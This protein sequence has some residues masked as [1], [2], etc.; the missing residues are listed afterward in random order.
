MVLKENVILYVV[1]DISLVCQILWKYLEHIFQVD[2][3][4]HILIFPSKR[5]S[6]V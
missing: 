1:P 5:F 3:P 6:D 2:E 4:F